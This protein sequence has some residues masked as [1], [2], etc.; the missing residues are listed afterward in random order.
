[1]DDLVRWLVFC[2]YTLWFKTE[3]FVCDRNFRN[4]S[5]Y[6]ICQFARDC[7]IVLA[8]RF[9]AEQPF[10]QE[11]LAQNA[12]KRLYKGVFQILVTGRLNFFDSR[13]FTIAG[14]N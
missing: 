1:M 9:T 3:V 10:F 11:L 7:V 13:V 2:V 14:Y 12:G 6:V 4:S 5:E 8:L